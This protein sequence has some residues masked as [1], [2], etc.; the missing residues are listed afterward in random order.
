[1]TIFNINFGTLVELIHYI[2]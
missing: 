1:M 2:I